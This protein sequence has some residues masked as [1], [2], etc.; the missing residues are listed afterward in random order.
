MSLHV[1]VNRVRTFPKDILSVNDDGDFLAAEELAMNVYKVISSPVVG[2]EASPQ[3]E[4]AIKV[5]AEKF[6]ELTRVGFFTVRG[7]DH[8]L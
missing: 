2:Y 4:M 5:T 1:P 7:L 6:C 3:S 8:T